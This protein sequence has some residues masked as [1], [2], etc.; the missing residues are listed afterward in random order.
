[1]DNVE[2]SLDGKKSIKNYLVHHDKTE[3]LDTACS[4]SNDSWKIKILNLVMVIVTCYIPVDH[5]IPF[6]I[7]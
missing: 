6:V 5:S 4:C 7:L 1:M 2:S 3:T